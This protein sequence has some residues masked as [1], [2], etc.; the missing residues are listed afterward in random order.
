MHEK[1]KSKTQTG[2]ETDGCFRIEIALLPLAAVINGVESGLLHFWQ[3]IVNTHQ[4]TEEQ[5]P[6][7]G[8]NWRS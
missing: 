3:C 1:Q 6:S 8:I 4:P 5:P 7:T 2:G